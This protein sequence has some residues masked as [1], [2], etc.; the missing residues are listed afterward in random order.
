MDVKF[1]SWKEP[2]LN[3]PTGY[4]LASS[5]HSFSEGVIN[6]TVVLNQY[7]ECGCPASANKVTKQAAVLDFFSSRYT[8][9]GSLEPSGA[10]TERTLAAR[11]RTTLVLTFLPTEI[12]SMPN[13]T[14][15][16]YHG[17]SNLDRRLLTHTVPRREAGFDDQK[18]SFG[19]CRLPSGASLRLHARQQRL[20]LTKVP[21]VLRDQDLLFDPRGQ[22]TVWFPIRAL[23]WYLNRTQDL[24]GTSTSLFFLLR[25]PHSAAW[26]DTLSRCLVEA[27]R[28]L[29]TGPG[30]S[31]AHN[32]R[33]FTASTA[34]FAG[35]PIVDICKTT[36]GRLQSL[37][38]LLLIGHITGRFGFGRSMI[39]APG[40]P[41]LGPPT[42]GSATRCLGCG[43]TGNG[44]R[45][46]YY[47][48]YW[49]IYLRVT[50]L[51]VSIS[52]HPPRGRWDADGGAVVRPDS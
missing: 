21:S 29:A 42:I 9:L 47:K 16:A 11:V 27:I 44:E 52:R 8:G 38:R 22:T 30:R 26:E 14:D 34:L 23:K 35:F 28:P 25:V 51:P 50:H 1:V 45:S 7:C 13:E 5:G 31:M 43:E 37:R 49:F 10:Q 12:R 48:T 2:P 33:G 46:K 41:P 4:S 39:R 32:S 17:L 24:L 36:R 40:V 15:S 3:L 6:G 20:A 19:C 18:L